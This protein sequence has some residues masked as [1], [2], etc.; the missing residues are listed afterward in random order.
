[1]KH[2]FI[3]PRIP[4][5]PFF[6]IVLLILFFSFELTSLIFGTLRYPLFAV[7]LYIVRSILCIHLIL[8]QLVSCGESRP[9]P[10][11]PSFSFR[12]GILGPEYPEKGTLTFWRLHW[13]LGKEEGRSNPSQRMPPRQRNSKGTN[14]PPTASEPV[15][16]NEEVSRQGGGIPLVE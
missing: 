2:C 16:E 5:A 14:V 8:K 7:F 3:I 6:F 1:M 13:G 4:T 15:G 10:P 12:P 11:N 9:G